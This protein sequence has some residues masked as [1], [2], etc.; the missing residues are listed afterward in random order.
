MDALPGEAQEAQNR[1]HRVIG[2]ASASENVLARDSIPFRSCAWPLLAGTLL[3][4]RG[5][6]PACRAW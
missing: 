4:P 5:G 3:P 2:S 1:E 6:G